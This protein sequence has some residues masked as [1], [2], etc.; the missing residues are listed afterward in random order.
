MH[1]TLVCDATLRLLA[2]DAMARDLFGL[3]VDV[4]SVALAALLAPHQG[5]AQAA[6]RDGALHGAAEDTL[7]G[8]EL[9]QAVN[10]A[11]GRSFPA[12]LWLR[13]RHTS[14][15]ATAEMQIAVS[16]EPMASTEASA[17]VHRETGTICDCDDTFAR[18]F[19]HASRQAI[20][21]AGIAAI[22]PQHQLQPSVRLAPSAACDPSGHQTVLSVAVDGSRIPLSI[23][24]EGSESDDNVVLHVCA[25]T[26]ADSALT[27]S[28]DGRIA[29]CD[30]FFAAIVFGYTRTEL[31]HQPVSLLL[32]DLPDGPACGAS[33]STLLAPSSTDAAIVRCKTIGRSRNG[34]PVPVI[35]WRQPRTAN[36]A[37]DR[38]DGTQRT[39]ALAYDITAADA[40]EEVD[41]ATASDCSG[42]QAADR[43]DRRPTAEHAKTSA[44]QCD[45]PRFILADAVAG[46]FSQQYTTL[47]AIGNGAFGFVHR[48]RRYDGSVDVA[49]KFIHKATLRSHYWH[50]DAHGSRIPLEAAILRQVQHPNIIQ[51]VDVHDNAAYVQLAMEYVGP[52]I[53]LFDYI[54]TFGTIPEPLAVAVFRQLSA[55]VA[56][57]HDNGIVHRDIKDENVILSAAFV[58]KLIDFGAAAFVRPGELFHTFSGTLEYCSPEI[59]LGC[60]YRGPELDAWA[61]GVTLYDMIFGENPFSSIEDTIAGNLTPPFPVSNGLLHLL[62][63]ALYRSPDGRATVRNMVEHAWTRQPVDAALLLG[64]ICNL[65]RH[66]ALCSGASSAALPALDAAALWGE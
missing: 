62:K 60:H 50:E 2:A 6:L 21:G 22:L 52:S 44:A 38:D 51:C 16:V 26:A 29:D 45:A 11:T 56:Y 30:G 42:T 19:G 3:P 27:L 28:D 58:V 64:P 53:D 5:R 37:D 4:Q 59:L 8:G 66:F 17:T 9:V 18:L 63:W 1:A 54:E 46:S 12:A 20:L 31:L 35:L 25:Y 32:P 13:R 36:G 23:A 49:V 40:A 65:R 55:A 61:L 48:A 15:A 43:P 57:L 39:L 10:L 47:Q 14:V 24:L 34:S 33:A 41:S 7:I